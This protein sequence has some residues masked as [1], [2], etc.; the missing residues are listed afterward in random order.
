MKVEEMIKNLQS[1][2]GYAGSAVL[3]KTGEITHIDD[4]KE[5]DLAFSSSL[6]NDTFRALNEASLDIGVSNLIR[7]ETENEEGM[8]FLIYG[9]QNYNIFTIFN[10]DSNISLAKMVLIKALRKDE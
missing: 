7:L 9:N 6:F 10:P 3:N 2:N 8:I 1:I 4:N 5:I